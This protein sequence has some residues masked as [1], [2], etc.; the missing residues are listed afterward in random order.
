VQPRPT[1]TCASPDAALGN[2]TPLNRKK[3]RCPCP[4]RF[5]RARRAARPGAPAGASAEL[6]AALA[7]LVRSLSGAPHGPAIAL[8]FSDLARLNGHATRVDEM[9]WTT[10]RTKRRWRVLA[11]VDAE[12][13]ELLER[14][15]ELAAV[16]EGDA[17]ALFDALAPASAPTPC[18]TNAARLQG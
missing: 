6:P 12:A 15:S 9:L 16:F 18:A 13:H 3:K 1:K 10:A 5:R 4:N 8:V 7:A 2:L 11:V 14:T 17:A